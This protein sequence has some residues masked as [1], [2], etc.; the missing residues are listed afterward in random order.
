[1]AKRILALL[2][3]MV[4]SLS[5]VIS[6]NAESAKKKILIGFAINESEVC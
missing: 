6:A 1:M 5:M 2:L 4:L 3:V